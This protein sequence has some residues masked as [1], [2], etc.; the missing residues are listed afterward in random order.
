MSKCPNHF[1]RVSRIFALIGATFIM[2]RMSTLV[3]LSTHVN[4]K[5]QRGMCSM[6]FNAFKWL[7]AA[8]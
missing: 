5:L 1:S 3:A 6:A 4:P 2:A 8:G 7:V